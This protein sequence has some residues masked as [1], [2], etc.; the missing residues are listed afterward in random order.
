MPD[1]TPSQALGVE[2]AENEDIAN[3]KHALQE[4]EETLSTE[5]QERACVSTFVINLH[6]EVPIKPSSPADSNV[7][8]MKQPSNTVN[9]GVVEKISRHWWIT[10]WSTS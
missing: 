6:R 4:E 5:L 8:N 7:E 9:L 10:R 1:S 3:A 2:I